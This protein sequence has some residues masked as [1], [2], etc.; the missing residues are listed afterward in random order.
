[1]GVIPTEPVASASTAGMS[2]VMPIRWATSTTLVGPTSWISWA[3]TT[4]TE[5]VVAV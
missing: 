5:S 4:F 3:N 1:M 2:V